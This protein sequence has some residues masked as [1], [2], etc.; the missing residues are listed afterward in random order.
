[1]PTP[2]LTLQVSS[3][4]DVVRARQRAR[5]IADGLHFDLQAQTKFV[6][7][8]S[9]IVRN[10]FRYAGGAQ[11]SFIFI[12]DA[13]PAIEV[14]VN[15]NGPGIGDLKAVLEGRYQSSTGL[16]MGIVGARRLMDRM[17]IAST[18]GLGTRV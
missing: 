9:E 6:T 14:Q 10:G 16:G 13:V 5:Q 2:L 3:E 18:P 11:V 1:M 7:A 12:H 17:D 15:D 8:V 4:H